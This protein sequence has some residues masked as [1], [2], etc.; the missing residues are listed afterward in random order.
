MEHFTLK[1]DKEQF[2]PDH[3]DRN[4][5][6][7]CSH[8]FQRYIKSQ[9]IKVPIIQRV[10][11]K[12]SLKQHHYQGITSKEYEAQL[13]DDKNILKLHCSVKKLIPTSANFW[14]FFGLKK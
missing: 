11:I 12:L 8:R 5:E 4:L 1:I 7:C 14:Q 3:D 6:L 9:I 13:F 10:R 2:V